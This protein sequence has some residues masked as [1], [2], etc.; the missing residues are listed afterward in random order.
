MQKMGETASKPKFRPPPPPG[1]YRKCG[2][3]R[4]MLKLPKYASDKFQSATYT[5]N[6][7]NAL[8]EK[9]FLTLDQAAKAMRSQREFLVLEPQHYNQLIVLDSRH[10][11]F[12]PGRSGI[13]Q[14]Y[15]DH[16]DQGTSY[17]VA[18]LFHE[19]QGVASSGSGSDPWIVASAS[20]FRKMFPKNKKFLAKVSNALKKFKARKRP[21]SKSLV[22][23]NSTY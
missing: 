10:S 19:F 8:V 1:T 12:S 16:Y 18:G 23:E 17:R 22:V 2:N 5:D 20:L 7:N 14:G 13:P 4:V 9:Q 3:A 6:K 11:M 15:Y 21:R